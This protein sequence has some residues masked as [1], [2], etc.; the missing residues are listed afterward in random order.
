MKAQISVD[1]TLLVI[2]ENHTESYALRRWWDN[3]DQ[4]AN[5]PDVIHKTESSVISVDWE[6]FPAGQE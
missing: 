3:F 1:G 2:A 4:S 6:S 5:R